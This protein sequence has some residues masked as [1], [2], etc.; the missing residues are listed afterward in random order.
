MKSTYFIAA[1]IAF[2]MLQI[3]A[4]GQ[5]THF[6]QFYS[7]PMLINPASTGLTPGPYRI[8]ANYRTQWS[9]GS[10]PYKTFTVSGDAH[11]LKDQIADGNRLGI[12]LAIVNDKTLQGAVQTNSIALSAGYHVSLDADQ[13]QTVSAGFQGTYN[14]RRI[15]FSNL[16]FENQFDGTGF[17]PSLPAGETFGAG[18]KYYLD[19]NA[20]AMY[21]FALEDKSF[22]AGA[23]M[24][25][26]LKKEDSYLTEQFSTPSLFSII[27][28]GD[29]DI[30]FNHSLY[31]S[32]NYR[33]QGNARETTI[34]M[35]YGVFIDQEGYTALKLG[36][37][38]RLNDAVI[39][40]A[41]L[42]YNGVQVGC[43][44]DYTTSGRKTRATARNAFE[45]SI[46]YIR[47]NQDEL[48][49]LMPWY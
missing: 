42:T 36:L 49:R 37:W 17:D 23:A 13:I 11:I 14:E 15:D 10:S 22:F 33:Q 31:F 34:G 39:P 41:S 19:V 4:R 25:N 27:T 12:G 43:S 30:G 21:T 44:Y 2:I 45:I 1:F 38:H 3:A 32:G 28:G 6:S 46:M 9:E 5:S 7:T 29:I 26:I 8:A 40:Y 20:G 18:K 48:K 24:Y 35:A 16:Q 47:P